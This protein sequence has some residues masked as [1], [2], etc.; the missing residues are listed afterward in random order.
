MA[1]LQNTISLKDSVSPVLNK[2]SESTLKASQSFNGM[3]QSLNNASFSASNATKSLVSFKEVVAG[4]LLVTALTASVIGLTNSFKGLVNSSIQF[5]Q[6]ESRLLNLV[7]SQEKVKALNEQIYETAQRANMEYETLFNSTLRLSTTAKNLFPKPEDALHFNEVL[8]KSFLINGVSPEEAKSSVLQL[9]QALGSGVLQGDEFRSMAEAN[10]MLLEYIANYLKVPRSELKKMGADGKITG[11]IVKDSLLAAEDEIEEKFKN[12]PQTF[13]TLGTKIHNVTM[14]SFQPLFT[15]FTKLANAPEMKILMDSIVNNIQFMAKVVTGAISVVAFGMRKVI[16]FFQE[17][18]LAFTMLKG[19][20]GAA[21]IVAGILAAEYIALGVASAISAVGI[22]V[23]NSALLASPITWIVLGIGAICIAI[24]QLVQAYEEWS[25]TSVSIIGAVAALFAQFGVQVANVFVGLWNYVAAVANFFANVWKDPLGAVQN[26]FI[27]IWNAIAGYVAQSI[28]NIIDNINKIPG[29]DKVF[30]GPINHVGSLELS[31]V[32]INGGETTLM[33][34]KNYIEASPY[35][36]SAYSWGAN[37]GKGI[38]DTINDFTSLH[39]DIKLPEGN[40]TNDMRN[41]ASAAASE[42]A[43]NSGKTA[44]N[45][46][47]MAKAI[48]LT[49]D[50]IDRLHQ[51]IMNDAIKQWSNRTIHMNITNNNNIDSSVNYGEFITD[52]ASGLGSAFERNTGE[53]L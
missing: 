14:K 44:K 30:G 19:V 9:N 32:A 45:T 2:I 53:A 39:D 10:P 12:L 50:E 38:S 16:G 33:N 17:H 46:E 26:L 48:D 42:T 41:A 25:G 18:K 1:E 11:Q 49:K 6:Y 51:G 24:Y 23:S 35:V 52:F 27:D 4:S 47:K 13:S 21:A 5:T 3:S 20:L 22:M 36:D 31:R 34:R 29:M 40:Q 37:V 7:G 8:N 15:L 43:K 28:N